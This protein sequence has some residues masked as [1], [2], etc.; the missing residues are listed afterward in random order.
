MQKFHG[1]LEDYDVFNVG[2]MAHMYVLCIAPKSLRKFSFKKNIQERK[3]VVEKN[4][5][6]RNI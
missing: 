3:N 4:K 5:I 6:K 2:P 1:L